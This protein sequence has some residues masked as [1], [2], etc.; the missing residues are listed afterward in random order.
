MSGD[1][2]VLVSAGPGRP[3]RTALAALSLASLLIAGWGAVPTAHAARRAAPRPVVSVPHLSLAQILNKNVTARGGLQHWRQVQSLALTG[4]L[5]LGRPQ[6][7]TAKDIE[8]IEHS[9]V[10]VHRSLAEAG[11]RHPTV[12]ANAPAAKTPEAPPVLLPFTLEMKRPHKV[13]L[14]IEY[15]KQTALQVFDGEK[16]WKL[17]PFTGR[18]GA[19]PMSAN[20]LKAAAADDNLDGMLIDYAAKGTHIALEQPEAVDGHPAYRLRLTLKDG[21]V[22]HVWVDA[23]TFLEVK[24][25]SPPR[26]IDGIMRTV[27]TYYRHYQPVNGLMIPFEVETRVDQGGRTGKMIIEQVHINPALDDSHFGKPA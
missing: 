15:H 25:D 6:V 24:V 23:K 10:R 14:A 17:R 4:T 22:R 2:R 21:N 9:N 18:Q 3:P 13:R 7:V 20:E 19:E 16:G 12:A 11:L 8:R 27:S 26:R 5:D 1:T